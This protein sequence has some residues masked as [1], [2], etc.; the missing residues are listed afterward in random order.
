MPAPQRPESP[1]KVLRSAMSRTVMVKLKDGSEFVGKLDLT[2]STMNVVLSEA[3][4]VKEG[5]NEPATK[6]GKILIRGSQ[7]L[8]ISTEYGE[9]IE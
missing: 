9:L 7:I 1:M 3:F 5:S 6:L 2:D 8:Y 4:Q